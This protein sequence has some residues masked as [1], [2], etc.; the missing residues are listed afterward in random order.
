MRR[1]GGCSFDDG[2][3]KE[4][5]VSREQM[6]TDLF[7]PLGLPLLTCSASMNEEAW[8]CEMSRRPQRP[9]KLEGG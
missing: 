6:P 9:R 4:S 7:C 1:S 8:S 5:K 2:T 3:S